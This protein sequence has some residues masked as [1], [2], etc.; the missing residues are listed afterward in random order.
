M[1]QGRMWVCEKLRDD[2]K[3][4]FKERGYEERYEAQSITIHIYVEEQ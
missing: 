2:V 1:K 4:K 3:G